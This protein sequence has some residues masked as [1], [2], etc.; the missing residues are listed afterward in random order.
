MI[1]SISEL[2]STEIIE[3]D[4][5][6]CSDEITPFFSWIECHSELTF[7]TS[8][9]DRTVT[10]LSDSLGALQKIA[11]SIFTPQDK[12]RS[13]FPL[14][15]EVL[16]NCCCCCYDYCEEE[17]TF[18]PAE[19]MIPLVEGHELDPI[20]SKENN[21]SPEQCYFLLNR[22][23][24]NGQWD[25]FEKI[26]NAPY[27]PT[28]MQD[29]AALILSSCHIRE[30]TEY[31]NLFFSSKICPALVNEKLAFVTMYHLILQ[32][33]F[34]LFQNYLRSDKIPV[35]DEVWA[36]SLFFWTWS[37]SEELPMEVRKE[38]LKDLL[39]SPKIVAS[40]DYVSLY[41]TVASYLLDM[42]FFFEITQHEKLA[43]LDVFGKALDF[44]CM[45]T[46]S[47][48]CCEF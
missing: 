39:D 29:P 38:R 24:L 47:V 19:Y 44:I 8:L 7:L 26:V 48:L 46:F 31:G 13:F 42:D 3:W 22:S 11:G 15:N 10:V 9:R 14:A 1:E 40:P 4:F 34:D 25:I 2:D 27:A 30:C 18:I 21:C 23:V 32:G 33:N 41:G 43:D 16:L 36:Y 12:S 37:T 28:L 6:K 17:E 5:L 20:Y 45:G 35:F